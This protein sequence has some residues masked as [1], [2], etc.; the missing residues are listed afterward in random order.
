MTFQIAPPR[1]LSGVALTSVQISASLPFHV[2]SELLRLSTIK[3]P[4]PVYSPP[5]T[6]F[7]ASK[8]AE[9]SP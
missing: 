4:L 9:I 1:K 2:S 5:I 6:A 7:Y 3:L 8:N